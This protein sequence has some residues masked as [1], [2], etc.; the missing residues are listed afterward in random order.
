[1]YNCL[2]FQVARAGRFGTKGLA[3]TFVSDETDVK[4]L[5]DV[6]ERF[7]VNITELPDEIDISSYSMYHFLCRLSIEILL[8]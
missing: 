6:Q 1:M 8:I 7:E 5:N 4:V 2:Y 3:I